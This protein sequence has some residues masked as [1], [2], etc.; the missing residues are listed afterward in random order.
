VPY[1]GE[2]Y[3]EQIRNSA[4]ADEFRHLYA[5]LVGFLSKEHKHDGKHADVNADSVTVTENDDTG[6]TGE[7][8][9]DGDQHSLGAVKIED[10]LEDVEGIS[11]AVGIQ[12]DDSTDGWAIFA[13]PN[14]TPFANSGRELDVLDFTNSSFPVLRLGFITGTSAYHVLP[15]AGETVHLGYNGGTSIERWASATVD[16]IY[17]VGRTTANGNMTSPAFS[18]GDYTAEG[19]MTWTVASGDVSTY[20]YT[21]LGPKLMLVT[22][23]IITSTVGGTPDDGLNVAIPASHTAA[24]AMAVG[25]DVIDNGT[26]MSGAAHVQAGETVLY[27]NII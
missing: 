27:V 4:I 8:H 23:Y 22:A 20:A 12:L 25:C 2:T 19:S 21:F 7:V 18:A 11:G 1:P 15:H 13:T 17:Q 5:Q 16:A 26:A 6:A 3:V 14:R 9:A 24:K 10:D